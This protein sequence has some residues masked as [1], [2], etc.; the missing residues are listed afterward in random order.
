MGRINNHKG[1]IGINWDCLKTVG[2]MVILATTSSRRAARKGEARHSGA[3]HLFVHFRHG[4]RSLARGIS[5][6]GRKVW[7]QRESLDTIHSN[8]LSLGSSGTESYPV[9]TPKCTGC[10]G[11]RGSLTEDPARP[12]NAMRAP[13]TRGPCHGGCCFFSGKIFKTCLF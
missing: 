13:A 3:G 2:H 9:S 4:L 7:P 6:P 1:R 8:Q 11:G 12:P 5:F 10:C